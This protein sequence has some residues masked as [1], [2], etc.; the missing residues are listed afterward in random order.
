ML[1]DT[2]A[3]SKLRQIVA[4]LMFLLFIAA[5][6][7]IFYLKI[8]NKQPISIIC[9]LILSFVSTFK[10]NISPSKIWEILKE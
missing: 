3:T 1:I 9:Y 10:S 8:V 2:A 4:N 7:V 6:N 5:L